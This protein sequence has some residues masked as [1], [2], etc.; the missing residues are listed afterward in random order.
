[1]DANF[2]FYIPPAP[3]KITFSLA[4]FRQYFESGHLHHRNSYYVDQIQNLLTY[5]SR[6][7]LLIIS[8]SDLVTRTPKV[9]Y[10]KDHKRY[11]LNLSYIL[12]NQF[13]PPPPP[14]LLLISIGDE[15]YFES[16]WYTQHMGSQCTAA[17][18]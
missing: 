5:F 4:T 3:G 17:S 8:F 14:P 9:M 12:S 16:F 1:M 7:Q 10:Q 6:S 13:T 2:N 11:S 18:R 15:C